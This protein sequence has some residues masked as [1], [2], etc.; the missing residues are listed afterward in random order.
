MGF[1]LPTGSG[2]NGVLLIGEAL[3]QDESYQGKPFVGA[4]GRKLDQ[5]LALIG[6][7]RANFA[8]WNI[9]AC[10]PPGNYLR[11]AP[12]EE[13]AIWHCR[14]YLAK[15]VSHY[16]PR[17]IVLL[18]STA[19]RA[20]LGLD[21]L[22]NLPTFRAPKRGYIYDAFIDGN[23][24]YAV[25][26]L[27]PAALFSRPGGLANAP[28]FTGILIKDLQRAIALAKDGEQV[29]DTNYVLNPSRDDID[30]FTL[31]AREAIA[32]SPE[33]VWLTT[34]IETPYGSRTEDEEDYNENEDIIRISFAFREGHA[35]T[36]PWLQKHTPAIQSLLDLVRAPSRLVVWN[37]KFDVPRLI[38]A[39]MRIDPACVYDAMMAWHYLQSDLPKSLGFVGSLFTTLREWKS[40]A[41]AAPE[42]YSCK[43]SDAAITIAYAIRSGLEG[44]LI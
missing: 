1:S 15:V 44:E 34:D 7:P 31:D 10:R 16:N 43:D 25:P 41:Q 37:E 8:I 14:Q 30:R 6:E 20:V 9:I 33:R 13:G 36:I 38:A 29:V 18:G 12:W 35:I 39:G 40:E 19:L 42:L 21:K 2:S 5:C 28:R 23:R 11:G 4:A 32:A 27:H 3:G 24:V 22:M 26:T 17:V